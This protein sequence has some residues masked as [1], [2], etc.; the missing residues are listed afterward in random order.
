MANWGLLV[1]P[2]ESPTLENDQLR[3]HRCRTSRTYLDIE[4][5]LDQVRCYAFRY[6]VPLHPRRP[7]EKRRPG[8]SSFGASVFSASAGAFAIAGASKTHRMFGP[9]GARLDAYEVLQK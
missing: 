4:C 1:G 5:G 3:A 8:V 2:Q 9:K 7:N 6:L